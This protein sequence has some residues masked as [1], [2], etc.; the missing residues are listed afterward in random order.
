MR[1]E[2]TSFFQDFKSAI[3]RLQRR[4]APAS[5]SPARRAG[6]TYLKNDRSTHPLLRRDR[7]YWIRGMFRWRPLRQLSEREQLDLKDRAE[8][9]REWRRLRNLGQATEPCRVYIE[10]GME[11]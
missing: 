11:V 5:P 9:K 1:D 4:S 3:G 10:R 6:T 8:L 7:D 2:L